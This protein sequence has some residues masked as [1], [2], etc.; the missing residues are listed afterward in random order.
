[1]ITLL[2]SVAGAQEM[3]VYTTVR[4]VA[5]AGAAESSDKAPVIARS[6]TLFHAGKVYDYV[7]AAK[8]VT[9]F[10]P[11]R[12]R[13]ILVNV[14]RRAVT[15][16]TQ[17]EVR[18][19][20][21]LVEQEAWKRLEAS[22]EQSGTAQARAMAWLKFQLKPEFDVSFDPSKSIVTLLEHGSRYT[23]DG[24]APPS[25]E[26]LESYLRFADAAAELNS[27]LHPQAPLPRPRLR[28]NDELRH[29]ELLPIVVDL[30][31]DLDRPLHLQA[32]HE[33]TWKF[34]STDRELISG[35]EA[36]LGD[37]TWRRLNFRN[38]QQE[39]LTAEVARNR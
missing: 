16:V 4:N 32:R 8:E 21:T 17:D 1:M 6:L 9:I 34:Q 35:W 20:L 37:N 13:F 24:Q 36:M 23:A 27:V 15:E 5:A 39:L 11:S 33:W 7:E 3:R 10:E 38:Y 18:Q 2:A 22:R 26:V 31:A 14:G 25:S 28:L 30:R 29:R 12:H 19:F